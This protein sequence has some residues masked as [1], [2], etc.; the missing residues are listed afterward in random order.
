MGF[1]ALLFLRDNGVQYWEEGKNVRRGWVGVRCPFCSDHSNHGGF[2]VV[3]GSY[4]CWRCGGHDIESVIMELLHVSF[5]RARQLVE[6]YSV[7]GQIFRAMNRKQARA[8]SVTMPGDPLT[9]FHRKYLQSR[10]FDP[11]YIQKKYGVLGTGPVGPFKLRIMIPIIY[12]GSVVSYTGRDITGK[13]LIR[14]KSLGIEESVIN[15]KHVLYNI[16]NCRR[17]WVCLVEGCLD[18][19]RMGDDFC[20]GLGTQ[21]TDQ[22]IRLLSNYRTVV[23]LFDPEREAQQKAERYASVLSSL[24][25]RVFVVDTESEE[26][27]GAMSDDRAHE[28]RRMVEAL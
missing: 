21:L 1:D 24:G 22:Q 17:D 13:Q 20:A 26:D 7:H 10:G 6:E 15:P 8:K 25:V 27:P 23:I 3:R 11:D 19:W 2:N 14:Y 12:H 5:S 28:V 18:V 16:D 4:S 9:E